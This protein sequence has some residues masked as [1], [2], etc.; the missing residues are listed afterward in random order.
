MVFIIYYVT[1]VLLCY[2][3]LYIN[4]IQVCSHLD[5]SSEETE[6]QMLVFLRALLNSGCKEVKRIV[7]QNLFHHPKLSS[8]MQLPVLREAPKRYIETV[9]IIIKNLTFLCLKIGFIYWQLKE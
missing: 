4:I 6:Y 1:I 8:M 9:I 3:R 5:C 2:K 7:S